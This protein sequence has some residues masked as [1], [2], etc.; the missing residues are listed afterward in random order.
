M[1][2]TRSTANPAVHAKPIWSPEMT[3]RTCAKAAV[4]KMVS[5]VGL[6]AIAASCSADLRTGEL[7]GV[8][9]TPPLVVGAVSLPDVGNGEAPVTMQPAAHKLYLVYFGYTSCPDVC[10]TTL[11]DINVALRDLP[12]A[13]ADRVTVAMVTVDPER[14]TPGVLTGYLAHFF[15][16]SI[17]L[18]TTDATQLA[19]AA[20]AFG[21]KFEVATHTPE[22]HSYYVAH[23][24]VTYVVDH[25]GT[26][27]VEWP[28]GL[29]TDDMTSD[30]L[31][32]LNK[33]QL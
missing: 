3:A 25:T 13:K 23:T 15:D 8:V 11:S 12:R 33:D 29:G 19:A 5:G 27:V 31:T 30:L 17:A 22:D 7:T 20:R 21:V 10:P 26:V 6:L 2:E 18:R 24:A 32:L 9:R 28:F 4:R 16:H 14:D 1:N